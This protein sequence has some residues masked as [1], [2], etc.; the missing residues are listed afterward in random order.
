M[1]KMRRLIPAFAMLMVAAIMLSTA[2]YAWFTMGTTATATGMHVTATSGSALLIVDADAGNDVAALF[3]KAGNSVQFNSPSQALT[4][5]THDLT[6]KTNEVLTYANGLKTVS[7]PEK[8]NAATGKY[9]TGNYK[10]TTENVHYV[11]FTALIA[12][13]GSEGMKDQ[14][15][16]ATVIISSNLTVL[17]H[18]AV[19]IDFW[20]STT[21]DADI[22]YKQSV[23]LLTVDAVKTE[24]TAGTTENQYKFKL[25]SDI[26][27]PLALANQN[28]LGDYITVTMRVY[29]DGALECKTEG[30]ANYDMTYVRN[31]LIDKTKAIFSIDFDVAPTTNP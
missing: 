17:L 10:E 21:K 18:N 4:P 6:T 14:D 11:E 9:D 23:N 22:D 15:L 25:A 3:L 30:D 2:S 5:A 20:V 27:V 24:S 26:D 8:V 28:S 7:D 19:T 12:A 31:Q 1:K 29:F 13:A 16:F